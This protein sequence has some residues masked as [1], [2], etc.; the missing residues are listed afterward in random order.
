MG[1]GAAPDL[2]APVTVQV[3]RFAAVH[4]VTAGRVDDAWH[5]LSEAGVELPGLAFAAWA[6]T[7]ALGGLVAPI[8]ANCPDVAT[9]LTEMERFHPLL[10]RDRVILARRPRSVT[11]G[12]R[13]AGGG[14]AHR[15]TVDAFFAIVSRMLRHLAGDRAQPSLVTLRRAAPPSGHGAHAAAFGVSPVFGAPADA[16]RFDSRV[17]QARIGQ[18]RALALLAEPDLPISVIAARTG[19][20]TPSAFTRAVRR[21]TGLA[22]SDLRRRCR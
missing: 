13:S 11:L 7:T 16:C 9:A 15:D 5:A 10:E 2:T 14:H 4:G 22:P 17:L 6:E 20:A 18:E 12:L 1:T 8:V 19:F 3:R 21:W